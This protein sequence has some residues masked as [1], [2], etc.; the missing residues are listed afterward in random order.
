MDDYDAMVKTLQDEMKAA[1][2]EKIVAEKQA[3]LDAFLAAK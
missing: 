2:I 3:Q 1:G